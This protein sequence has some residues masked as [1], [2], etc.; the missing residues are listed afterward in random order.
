MLYIA[1]ELR[2]NVFWRI[3]RWKKKYRL[4]LNLFLTVSKSG[5]GATGFVFLLRGVRTTY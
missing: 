1:A 4:F 5:I 2:K 3:L